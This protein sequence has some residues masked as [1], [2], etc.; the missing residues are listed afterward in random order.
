MTTPAN[1]GGSFDPLSGMGQPSGPQMWGTGP[2]PPMMGKP[3]PA[4]D[5][6]VVAMSQ[7]F[8]NIPLPEI[9]LMAGRFRDNMFQAL[10]TQIKHDMT[11]QKKASDAFKKSI[12]E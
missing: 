2:T 9:Q 3:L 7:M 6:W 5:P 1:G 10:N 4:N 11:E 12:N 8:P